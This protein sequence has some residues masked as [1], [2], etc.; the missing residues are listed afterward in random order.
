M[1]LTEREVKVSWLFF[2][3][4]GI[5]YS[6]FATAALCL[7]SK[8]QAGV[9]V[10]SSPLSPVWSNASSGLLGA[11]IQ[12]H[13][14]DD[15][16]WA[17]AQTVASLRQA[18]IVTLRF[19]G[20]ELADN[21]DWEKHA[22]ERSRGWPKEAV[23]DEG[24]L[25]RTD[26]REFLAHATEIGVREPFF[27]VNVDGAFRAAGDRIGNLERYAAKAAAWVVAVKTLGFKVR[28]WEIGNEPYLKG[29][30]LT[31]D[32]YAQVLTVFSKKMRAA[33]PS[34]LIGAAGPGNFKGVGFGDRLGPDSLEALRA[35]K[36]PAKNRCKGL[37]Y[38][39][40]FDELREGRSA[41]RQVP[42]WW[43]TLLEQS[44]KAFDFVAVHRYR[45][46]DVSADKR[47]GRFRLTARLR[48][49]KQYLERAK[50]RPVSLTLTE[51]NTP[52]EERN[53]SLSEIEHLLEIAIQFGNNAVAGVS[54][55][56]YWPM[57]ASKQ[58]AHKALLDFAGNLKPVG[59][60]FREIKGIL[61][62]NV[63]VSQAMSGAG[64][65]SLT[66][67]SSKL[68]GYLFANV[69]SSAAQAALEELAGGDVQV[70]RMVA[71]QEGRVEVPSACKDTNV[72]VG[73]QW[74]I[75]PPQSV[76]IVQ[77]VTEK[78]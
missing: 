58:F 8:P 3:F 51:W 76:T 28:Y 14:D 9:R 36:R 13:Y 69:G 5:F 34:I 70:V 2:G 52:N 45:M 37:R 31:A 71:D 53:R 26:Y 75:I 23:T 57:R 30:P 12:Y 4:V 61:N 64:V 60:L 49:L 74:L 6:G 40:C 32:E 54:F 66:I 21:Y 48:Q 29:Y 44:A 20:G 46:S 67:R 19:P 41:P 78:E 11:S 24:R 42:R 25:L 59:W 22:L 55:A 15:A 73:R 65:Y 18:G 27:V 33:D 35:S 39:A 50:G 17:K 43:P 10:L 47:L 16:L 68:N 77:R 56:H 7:A 62:N 72:A 1:A 63:Q 38:T